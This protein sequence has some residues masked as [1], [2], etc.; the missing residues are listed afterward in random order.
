MSRD[1]GRGTDFVC[2]DDEMDASGG[3]HVIQ[4]FVSLD[5]SEEKQIKGRTARQGNQGSY[6][7]VLLDTELTAINISI[8]MIRKFEASGQRYTDID[9]YRRA[10]CDTTF[11]KSLT[12]SKGNERNHK[13]SIAFL[14]AL[15]RND[16]R[17]V[18]EYLSSE[19]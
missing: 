4:T 6:S 18:K 5:V 13:N 3:V 17:A 1:F 16:V 11:Q 7:L 8:E 9:R 14:D 10:M 15:Y 2:F 12:S 19:F